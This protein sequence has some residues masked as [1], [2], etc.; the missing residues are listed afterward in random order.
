MVKVRRRSWSIQ[1]A[2]ASTPPCNCRT[3]RTHQQNRNPE[4]EKHARK[5]HERQREYAE[6]QQ[7]RPQQQAVRA[8][9]ALRC[10]RA[11]TAQQQN[12]AGKNDERNDCHFPMQ[13]LA[14]T[15]VTISSFATSPLMCPSAANAV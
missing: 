12:H 14:N 11:Q 3:E 7:S 4:R 15:P 10:A 1:T 9:A 2:C 5:Q 13:N 6:K 8:A